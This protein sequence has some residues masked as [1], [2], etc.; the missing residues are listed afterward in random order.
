MTNHELQILSDGLQPARPFRFHSFALRHLK[1]AI[2]PAICNLFFAF[3]VNAHESPIDHVDRTLRLYVEAGQLYVRYNLRQTD[4]AA[5]LQLRSMDGDG[6]GRVNTAERERYLTD[7][8]E[9]LARQLNA[10]FNDVPVDLRPVGQ[11][12]LNPDFSQTFLFVAKI[13]VLEPGIYRGQVEDHHSRSYPG[14]FTILGGNLAADR[15]T[16]R[17]TPEKNEKQHK[18]HPGMLVVRFEVRVP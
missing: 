11:L 17:V 10:Q 3:P 15:T 2:L 5:F 16:V 7:F 18:G 9:H 13:G 1:V 6:D 14:S 8:A 4:R 12:K